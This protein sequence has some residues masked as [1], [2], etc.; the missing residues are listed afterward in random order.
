MKE[1]PQNSIGNY[2]GPIVNSEPLTL[3]V[4]SPPAY[5]LGVSAA[6]ASQIWAAADG[7]SLFKVASA[8]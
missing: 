6:D 3:K 4:P 2:L 5:E 1:P 7:G 8:A